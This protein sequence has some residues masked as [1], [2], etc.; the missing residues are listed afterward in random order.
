MRFKVTLNDEARAQLRGLAPGPKR[1]VRRVL[2]EM[3]DDPFALDYRQLDRPEVVYRIR[4]GDY[5]I[6]F[7][8]GPRHREVTVTRVGHRGWVYQGL[9]RSSDV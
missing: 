7:E 6:V 2:R 1:L 8:P 4:E 3:E 9:G 5:R